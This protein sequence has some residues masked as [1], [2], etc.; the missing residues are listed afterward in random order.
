MAT[1]SSALSVKDLM[2][3]PLMR[4]NK[5]LELTTKAFEELDAGVNKPVDLGVVERL[6]G[7]FASL[8]KA[9]DK[10]DDSA[11]RSIPTFKEM[12][13]A[14]GLVEI[15]KQVFSAISN[16]IGGAIDYA[17]D[18]VE[19]QNVVDV[20][21][22]KSAKQVDEWAKQTLKAY[23]INELSAKNFAGTMGA[24]LKSSG[25]A[26]EKV[27]EMSMNI[28]GLAGDMASFYNLDPTEAFNKIRSG[29]SGE[30]EPLKQLGID[31][32]VAALQS[33]ALANGMKKKVS[34]MSKAE[35]TTLRY[36]YL[37]E[38]T[39]D[40]QGDFARTTDSFS[41]QQKLLKENWQQLVG[42]LVTG[43]LPVL[44]SITKVFNDLLTF[45]NDH[46]ET[47]QAAAVAIG[48]MA[49]AWGLYAAAQWLANTSISASIDVI[50]AQTV[51]L[52]ANP[53]TW[54]ILIIGILVFAII[55]W[56]QSVGGLTNA[57]E[58]CKTA[59][60]VAWIA[61]K[62][63]FFTG[64][65]A[66][67][68]L[69]DML[70]MGI[71]TGL[72]AVADFMG[73]MKVKVLT[74][75]QNM[76]NGSIGLINDFIGVLN[77]IPGVNLEAIA[78][79]SFAATASAENEAGKSAR[80]DMMA[81]E[82]ARLLS[83]KQSRESKLNGLKDNLGESVA[84][85]SSVYDKAKQS[86]AEEKADTGTEEAIE[87]NTGSTANSAKTTAGALSK[88][89]EEL[90]YLRDI[91]EQEIINRFTT[92]EVKIDYSGMSNT[93]SSNMDLD[94]VI[95]GLTEKFAQALQTTAE[96]VHV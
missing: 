35:L 95:S 38:K 39:K 68:D 48:V 21:F 85:L 58:I 74:I 25:L 47:I 46:I 28:A 75:L 88:T 54:I 64:V 24:M 90:K 27:S 52:L 16:A 63:A 6:K 44:A 67:I 23:G 77:K 92:A 49:V 94:G 22:G 45:L 82:K 4:I 69:I 1:I 9:I 20:T 71:T 43:L 3:E 36:N 72:V 42:A 33:Y 30:T 2:S 10:V 91:A 12:V 51:A 34:E 59:L 18:L 87:E 65:Y 80:A 50:W 37:L 29:I 83:E 86:K 53:I 76:I 14:I 17:S 84:K 81:R 89:V 79:V 55:R 40:A 61:L 70:G 26:G 60:V 96:G 8:N 11:K 5:S 66:I 19:S 32:S 73:D 62:L 41:N 15:G 57:W 56:I 93:I 78:K 7:E 31:M 13:G